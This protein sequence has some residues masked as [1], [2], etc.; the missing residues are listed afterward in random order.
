MEMRRKM[1]A[2][3]EPEAQ[4]LDDNAINLTHPPIPCTKSIK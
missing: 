1:I 2:G 3:V 4:S